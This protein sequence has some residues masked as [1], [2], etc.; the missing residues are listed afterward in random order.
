MS[1]S[2]V[3]RGLHVARGRCQSCDDQVEQPSGAAWSASTQ[4]SRPNSIVKCSIE[5]EVL[6]AAKRYGI[7]IEF[8]IARA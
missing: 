7:G 1:C 3:R 4:N 2:S 5:R 8:A 6:P